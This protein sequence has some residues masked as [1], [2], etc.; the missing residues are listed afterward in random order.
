MS[1]L[2][3]DYLLR[4]IEL[5][6]Q[7]TA[8]LAGRRPDRELEEALLLAFHLQERLLPLPPHEFLQLDLPGQLAALRRDETPREGNAKCRALA[9]L[10]AE[11]AT[12]YGYKGHGELAGGAR[13]LALYAAL[14]AAVGDPAD[15]TARALVGRLV[16]LLDPA[17]L[18]PPV[19]GLLAEFN[20]LPSSAG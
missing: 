14:S 10:L 17:C 1:G 9:E 7:F 20:A 5:L 16:P 15:A 18:H 11:T 8:R 6:R 19:A 13:Q 4:Q 3:Q 12:L 2:R